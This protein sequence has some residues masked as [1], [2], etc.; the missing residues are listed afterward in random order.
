M[1]GVQYEFD[2]DVA[3]GWYDDT[4]VQNVESVSG[5]LPV[6]YNQDRRDA[7]FK[8]DE[9]YQGD[10]ENEILKITFAD[11]K[12]NP[13]PEGTM[14]CLTQAP[15]GGELSTDLKLMDGDKEATTSIPLQDSAAYYKI[16]FID[17]SPAFGFSVGFTIQTANKTYQSQWNNFNFYVE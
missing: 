7:D 2:L 3:F 10:L 6:T 15:Q 5:Q 4:V 9:T 17:D 14:I 13:F 16:G 1:A 8:I 12:G 11:E